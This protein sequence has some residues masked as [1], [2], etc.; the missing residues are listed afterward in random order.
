MPKLSEKRIKELKAGY[1][2][3]R[4]TFEGLIKEFLNSIYHLGQ[5]KIVHTAIE[6]TIR[7][8][9][10]IR[11]VM[12]GFRQYL[13]NSLEYLVVIATLISLLNNRYHFFSN[14]ATAIM[15]NNTRTGI[16]QLDFFYEHKQFFHDFFKYSENYP[17]V[18]N[19]VAIPIFAFYTYVFFRKY[20]IHLGESIVLNTFIT[21]QQLLFLVFLVPFDEFLPTSKEVLLGVYT[22]STI[23]FNIWVYITFFEGKLFPK[24]LRAIAVVFVSY[25]LQFPLNALVYYIFRPLFEFISTL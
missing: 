15:D 1:N 19:I 12:R 5:K 9:K 4:Y 8:A 24:L 23:I 11:N 6:L 13:Y 25:F 10:A 18:V 22:F 14:E 21:A 3:E 20:R 17:S 2:P 7:P 16:Y